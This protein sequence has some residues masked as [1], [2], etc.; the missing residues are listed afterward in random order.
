MDRRTLGLT[1]ALFVACNGG[2]GGDD[3]PDAA[4]PIDFDEA[5]MLAHLGEDVVLPIYEQFRDEA[6]ALAG[7]V[8]AYCDALGTAG[9][10][11]ARESARDAWRA[12]MATWQ[13]A[14]LTQ[15]G[16]AS[17]AG[18]ALR[19]VIYSWPLVA[20]CSVDKEVVALRDD[21]TGYDIATKLTNRRGLDVLEYLLFYES[22]DTICPPLAAPKGWNEL[23]EAE[24]AAARCAYSRT[25][26][27]DL[28]AQSSALVDAWIPF[29]DEL[30]V[31][32]DGANLVFGALFYLD[33][34]TKDQ[35]LAKPAGLATNTC[36]V[37][38]APCA[39][40]LESQ[41]AHRSK[42]HVGANV[43]AFRLLFFGETLAGDDGIGFD[44][45]LRAAHAGDIAD[46]L[47]ADVVE[48][49]AAVEGM[50][51]TMAEALAGDY[52]SVV[53]AHTEVRDVTDA[54][55]GDVPATLGLRI[56]DEAGGDAD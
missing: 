8:D 54:L 50:P 52:A 47:L 31:D 44:D 33:L 35:K 38:D 32:P 18:D 48:A 6:G 5:A 4:P 36:S 43:R 23:P 24:R 53:G 46:A 30:V 13:L 28:A 55:K 10:V 39:L 37:Q 17:T 49:L 29:V 19:D 3:A 16:P 9:E 15:L 42:D 22:L 7:A 34:K 1:I 12:A 40:D 21:P 27:A 26:S 45:F 51:G 14:E 20:P 11:A 25:A 2:D 56:P 41:F